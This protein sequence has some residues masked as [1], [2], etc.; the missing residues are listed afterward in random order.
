[1]NHD[2]ETEIKIFAHGKMPVYATTTIGK[3][4][5]NHFWNHYNKG[6]DQ[7]FLQIVFRMLHSLNTAQIKKTSYLGFINGGHG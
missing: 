1:M 3:T 5:P 2:F 7:T 6:Y 4:N